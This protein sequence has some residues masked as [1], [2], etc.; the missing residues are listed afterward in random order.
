[1]ER[2]WYA[3]AR[4]LQE[5]EKVF[6]DAMGAHYEYVD[7]IFEGYFATPRST[8]EAFILEMNPVELGKRFAVYKKGNMSGDGVVLY[9]QRQPLVLKEVTEF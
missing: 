1:M 3:Y 9:A 4:W 8:Q 6:Q 2:L 5:F 7:R